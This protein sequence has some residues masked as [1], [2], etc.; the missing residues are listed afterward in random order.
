MKEMISITGE[1]I[2]IERVEIKPEDAQKAKKKGKVFGD[3]V[4]IIE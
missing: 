3:P 2:E 1:N 4:I